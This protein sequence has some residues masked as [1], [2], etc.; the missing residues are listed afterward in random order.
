[1]NRGPNSVNTSCSSERVWH[2]NIKYVWKIMVFNLTIQLHRCRDTLTHF[3]VTLCLPHSLA[4]SFMCHCWKCSM[5]LAVFIAKHH[6]RQNRCVCLCIWLSY[7]AKW[8]SNQFH[9]SNLIHKVISHSWQNVSGAVQAAWILYRKLV[10][11]SGWFEALPFVSHGCH[12]DA[13]SSIMCSLL[14]YIEH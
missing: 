4:L 5:M 6:H 14:V 1:M 10:L 11:I 7:S 8:F 2:P 12:A 13:P 3:A 9:I